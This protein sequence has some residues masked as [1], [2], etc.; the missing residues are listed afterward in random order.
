MPIFECK[1][2]GKIFKNVKGYK[3]FCCQ[4]CLDKYRQAQ[5]VEVECKEC[6]KK[7]FVAQSRAKKYVC[8]SIPCLQRY[9]SKRYSQKISKACPICGK[10]FFFKRSAAAH[11][12]TCGS[13]ECRSK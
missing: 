7:E 6:G 9:N 10:E 12:A 8:C 2:C 13:K 5:R 11:H 1:F 4:A 3:S